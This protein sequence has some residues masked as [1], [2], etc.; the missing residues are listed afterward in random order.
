MARKSTHYFYFI[1]FCINAQHYTIYQ[2]SFTFSHLFFPTY[3][4]NGCDGRTD[5]RQDRRTAGGR[6]TVYFITYRFRYSHASVDIS[7]ISV[8][9]FILARVRT[10]SSKSA[11]PRLADDIGCAITTIRP[12]KTHLNTS[13]GRTADAPMTQYVVT[14][15][16]WRL[17]WRNLAVGSS[18]DLL[19]MRTIVQSVAMEFLQAVR[20]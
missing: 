6:N 17:S 13:L 9:L 12:L 1:L 16:Q 3:L 7:L 5:S 18:L 14:W 2:V 4:L 11:V 10:I 19:I 15:K 20:T 8:F